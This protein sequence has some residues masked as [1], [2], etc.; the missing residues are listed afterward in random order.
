MRVTNKVKKIPL[1]LCINVL[2][3]FITIRNITA[4]YQKLLTGRYG[5]NEVRLD[6]SCS[7]I[8]VGGSPFP[9]LTDAIFTGSP[10]YDIDDFISSA[11]STRYL[12]SKKWMD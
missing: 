5:S 3:K 8:F 4:Q 12:I 10:D 7:I 1:I 6:D 9:I 2:P 11:Q